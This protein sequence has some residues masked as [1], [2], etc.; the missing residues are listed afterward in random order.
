MA[1]CLNFDPSRVEIHHVVFLCI[2][3]LNHEFEMND[4]DEE[5]AMMSLKQSVEILNLNDA[6]VTNSKD[7]ECTVCSFYLREGYLNPQLRNK[8]LQLHF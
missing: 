7:L 3:L 4:L 2:P 5:V 8:E 1:Y 6:Q